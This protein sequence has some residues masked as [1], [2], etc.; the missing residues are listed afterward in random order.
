[1]TKFVAWDKSYFVVVSKDNIHAHQVQ[2]EDV[3]YG[4]KK[5]CPRMCAGE[6]WEQFEAHVKANKHFDAYHYT[7]EYEEFVL[8]AMINSVEVEEILAYSKNNTFSDALWGYNYKTDV[9]LNAQEVQEVWES[10]VAKNEDW[11]L[12]SPHTVKLRKLTESDG[13]ETKIRYI[14]DYTGCCVR[15]ELW[16][17]EQ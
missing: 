17:R 8:F 1:M 2:K 15:S 5:Y 13:D 3:L 10:E 11:Y 6:A 12:A 7:E 4:I 16:R 9:E 14:N